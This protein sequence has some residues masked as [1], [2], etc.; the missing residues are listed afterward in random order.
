MFFTSPIKAIYSIKFYLQTIKEPLWKAFLFLVYLFVLGSIFFTLYVPVSVKPDIIN[1]ITEIAEI[2]P[3]INID[4][5]IITVNNNQ[6]LEIAPQILEGYKIV[7]DTASTEPGYP[8]QMEKDNVLMYVNKNKVFVTYNGQFQ[9]NEL[10]TNANLKFSKDIILQNQTQIADF[11]VYFMT[12]IFILAFFIRLLLLTAL[13]LL[14]LLII[15][16]SAKKS[17]GF[18]KSLILAIYMQAPVVSIDLILML[19]PMRILGMSALFSLLIYV[20]YTNLIFTNINK[21][22]AITEGKQEGA[23]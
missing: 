6:R 1:V 3:E 12:I 21:P 7:F 18:K 9:E 23:K 13:A 17:I 14:I 15:G 16:A 4:K 19:L 8:T 2:T 5:G 22:L 20:I 11:V 10:P